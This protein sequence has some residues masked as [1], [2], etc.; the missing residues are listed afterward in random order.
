M[1]TNI[2]DAPEKENTPNQVENY[3]FEHLDP[4]KGVNY[5]RLMER[6]F[7]GKMRHL[8][9]A[10]LT[11]KDSTL[12]TI[13]TNP[14]EDVFTLNFYADRTEKVNVI[15]YDI[16]GR[17][18]LTP[19]YQTQI[20]DNQMVVELPNTLPNGVYFIRLEQSGILKT[21]KFKKQS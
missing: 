14:T 5:Y 15:I 3:Q 20:G 19:Q 1:N 21:A 12:F 4:L 17:I 16:V 9:Q 6:G 8:A 13:Q 11:F 2:F 7:D 18:V 10:S